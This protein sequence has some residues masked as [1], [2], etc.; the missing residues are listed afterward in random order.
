M[1]NSKT[2][3]NEMSSVGLDWNDEAAAMVK[4]YSALLIIMWNPRNGRRI[5]SNV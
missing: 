1:L 2:K 4:I 5:L 3:G